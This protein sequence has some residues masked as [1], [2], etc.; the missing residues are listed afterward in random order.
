MTYQTP[1]TK[2]GC[3][4]SGHKSSFW[5]LRPQ[6]PHFKE[7][8]IFS[9]CCF[10]KAAATPRK[11]TDAILHSRERIF[12]KILRLL[13]I[14]LKNSYERHFIR[15]FQ[16]VIRNIQRNIGLFQKI[17]RNIQR[18]V[19]LFQEIIRNFQEIVGRFQKNV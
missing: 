11:N 10:G 13:N 3:P 8:L 9:V 16:E 4:H 12:G 6:D 14:Y 18:Q 2:T 19:R 1:F 5:G 17:I 15:L 7:I